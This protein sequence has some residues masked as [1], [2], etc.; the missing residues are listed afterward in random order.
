MG[1]RRRRRRRVPAQGQAHPPQRRGET[2]CLTEAEESEACTT[3][4][5]PAGSEEVEEA[6][7]DED[8]LALISAFF[9]K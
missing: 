6:D 5:I 9:S 3:A 1:L 8:E 4:R 2:W 7:E